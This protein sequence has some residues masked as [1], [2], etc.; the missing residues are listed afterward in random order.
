MRSLAANKTSPT[1]EYPAYKDVFSKIDWRL[2]PL[3]PRLTMT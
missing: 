3:L 1:L 2:I